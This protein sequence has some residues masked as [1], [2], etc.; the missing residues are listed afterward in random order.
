MKE[1]H[2]RY[3][4]VCV[5][6]FDCKNVNKWMRKYDIN[7]RV[8]FFLLPFFVVGAFLPFLFAVA[9]LVAPFSYTC[10]CIILRNWCIAITHT[11]FCFSFLLSAL[12]Y[13]IIHE[14]GLFEFFS[15]QHL[16]KKKSRTL[17]FAQDSEAL[18]F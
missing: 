3:L 17:N 6:L 5:C 7:K 1:K 9:L 15:G 16:S 18:N 2:L 14:R 12:K 11:I 10:R 4:Y 8:V 13:C